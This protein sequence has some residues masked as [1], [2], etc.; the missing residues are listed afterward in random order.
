[1]LRFHEP[2]QL[3][4]IKKFQ[5]ASRSFLLHV[6]L[7]RTYQFSLNDMKVEGSKQEMGHCAPSLRC[8]QDDQRAPAATG[9]GDNS[10]SASPKA[11]QASVRCY[12]LLTMNSRAG[13]QQQ[14]IPHPVCLSRASPCTWKRFTCVLYSPLNQVSCLKL[15]SILTCFIAAERMK[16]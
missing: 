5:L 3:G 16:P 8:S 15:H 14:H 4:L 2:L 13:L 12:H 10:P 9:C 7:N 11:K 6:W 1:M